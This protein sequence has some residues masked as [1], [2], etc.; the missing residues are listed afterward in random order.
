MEGRKAKAL[1]DR[2]RSERGPRIIKVSAPRI[3]RRHS[4]Q[5]GATPHRPLSK[6]C[7]CNAERQGASGSK[8]QY[9][10]RYMLDV[11]TRGSQ[12]LLNVQG[13]SR[14][15]SLQAEGQAAGIG[16]E[17]RSQCR[18]AGD[19]QLVDRP[20][21]SAHRRAAELHRRVRA[22]QREAARS[23]RAA[24]AGCRRPV[25]VPTV[26]GT[27][28]DGRRTLIIWRKLTGDPEQDNLVLDT[29]IKDR[30]QLSTRT[31]SSTSST[32]MATTIWRT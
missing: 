17:P 3:L 24:A 10:L 21:R 20:H 12:S 6:L 30:S 4:K 8:E 2:R 14:P 18:S 31:A 27:T 1:C 9:M 25:V 28:P 19:L 16:R 5:P 29:W 13:I 15:H 26:D 23:S 7:S 11:E 32:S 22:R